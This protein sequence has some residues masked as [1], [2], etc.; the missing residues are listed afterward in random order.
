MHLKHRLDVTSA[1]IWLVGLW[2]LLLVIITPR[3]LSIGE[4]F[5][6]ASEGDQAVYAISRIGVGLILGLAGVTLL[7]AMLRKTIP[8]AAIWIWLAYVIFFLATKILS[9]I[10]GAVPTFSVSWLYA[11]LIMTAIYLS[12]GAEGGRLLSQSKWILLAYIYVSLLAAIV[13]PDW[14][15]LG[16]Y[17]SLL[18]GINFRLFGAA[19]HANSLGVMAAGYMALEM[20]R[21][22]TSRWRA[23]NLSATCVVLLLA[24]SKTS[25]GFIAMLLAFLFLQT[26][27]R[28]ASKSAVTGRSILIL[29]GYIV[30][31]GVGLLALAFVFDFIRFGEG[32]HGSA[33]DT[34]TGR[35]YIWG[36]TMDIWR[37]SPI[38]GYGPEL[39]GEA[40][41]F[42]YGMPF[43][44]N[45]H[46]QYIDTLGSSGL[47]GLAGLLAYLAVLGY[48]AM[49]CANKKNMIPLALLGLL[50][51]YSLTEAPFRDHNIWSSFLLIHLLLV[52][53]LVQS[54]R[55]GD[56]NDI[57]G[58][59]K[60]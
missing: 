32:G 40:F 28:F 35:T 39:W 22:S 29:S 25:W 18:P 5:S 44:G 7:Q 30:S 33:L 46:N 45:A 21:P 24:Q 27:I 58:V 11:P 6:L 26:V 16:Q 3:D 14:A 50:V 56:S 4:Q 59:N 48:S 47:V 31:L 12:V 52:A 57:F 20:I 23:I 15:L 2:P 43:V 10:G 41:R 42:H 34:L 54:V 38:F 8:R 55:Y 51:T 19:T 53:H 60:Q 36:L 13:V 17:G 9:G 49:R 1:I 37:E